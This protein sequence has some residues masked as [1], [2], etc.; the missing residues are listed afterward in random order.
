MNHGEK[1]KGNIS[2]ECQNVESGKM[3][4]H[5]NYYLQNANPQSQLV[6]L[7]K[8]PINSLYVSNLPI[9]TYSPTTPQSLLSYNKF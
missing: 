6:F 5:R 2:V 8:F 9:L 7:I 3:P 4:D 1:E